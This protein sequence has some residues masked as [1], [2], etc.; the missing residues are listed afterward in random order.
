L[1]PL[2]ECFTKPGDV[3]LDPFAGSGSTLVAAAM[4]G[5]RYLGIELED[6]YCELA[7]G[8]LERIAGGEGL[9]R[10]R[11]YGDSREGANQESDAAARGFLNWLREPHHNPVLRAL[12]AIMQGQRT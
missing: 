5:R 8:R 9:D 11:S 4:T 6:K 1:R 3:V 7:R 12:E 2:I 10:G